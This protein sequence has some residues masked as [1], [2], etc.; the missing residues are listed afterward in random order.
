MAITARYTAQM[1]FVGTELHKRL[2]LRV[3]ADGNLSQA[4]IARAGLNML[5]SLEDEETL[6][7]GVSEDELVA[8]VIDHVKRTRGLVQPEGAAV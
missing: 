6:P 3:S 4:D 2:V 8:E 5:F 7:E 1:P